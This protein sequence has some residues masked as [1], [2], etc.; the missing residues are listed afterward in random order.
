LASSELAQVAEQRATLR[1]LIEAGNLWP[2]TAE[3]QPTGLD[4]GRRQRSRTTC[5]TLL[6][7]I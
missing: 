6:G 2:V 1:D 3:R 7:F 5:V 4:H